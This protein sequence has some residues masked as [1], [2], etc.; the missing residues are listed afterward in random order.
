[1]KV[2]QEVVQWPT[3]KGGPDKNQETCEESL[4]KEV[5]RPVDSHRLSS[6]YCFP[7]HGMRVVRIV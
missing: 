1:M 7:I 2:V 5:L 4:A 3:E 6:E